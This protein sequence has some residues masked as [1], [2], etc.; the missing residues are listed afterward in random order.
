M[1]DP[2]TMIVVFFKPFNILLTA[3]LIFVMLPQ[4]FLVRS[5]S[6]IK[7]INTH[8]KKFTK[9]YDKRFLKF[10][11]FLRKSSSNAGLSKS[12][13]NT[14]REMLLFLISKHP[15]HVDLFNSV[16]SSIENYVYGNISP[17]NSD[18][19]NFS[20]SMSVLRS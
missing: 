1:S 12:D 3:G 18:F 11:E 2:F 9:Q 4:L 13:S 14:I 17:S 7:K 8:E 15:T 19:K 20:K 5:K 6:L 16:L 10:L